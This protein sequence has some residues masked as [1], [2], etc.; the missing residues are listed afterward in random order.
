MVV[1]HSIWSC[2][3]IMVLMFNTCNEFIFGTSTRKTLD[4]SFICEIKCPSSP[5]PIHCHICRK[6]KSKKQFQT[7][8][9][10]CMGITLHIVQISFGGTGN[11]MPR[12]L[13]S[14]GSR[15]EYIPDSKRVIVIWRGATS[16]SIVMAFLNLPMTLLVILSSTDAMLPSNFEWYVCFWHLFWK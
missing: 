13:D 14:Y 15:L 9:I 8:F 12:C 16:T 6:H 10:I 7:M 4:V 11:V 1:D 5:H 3:N 2:R